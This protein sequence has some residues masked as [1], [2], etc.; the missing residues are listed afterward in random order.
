MSTIAFFFA[1]INSLSTHIQLYVLR[2][3]GLQPL[4]DIKINGRVLSMLLF[5][6]NGE[7]QDSLF[8]A[9]ERHR[10]C[11]LFYENGDVGWRWVG[12]LREPNSRPL[13]NQSI[14]LDTE[15]GLVGACCYQGSMTVI[16]LD[17][18]TAKDISTYTIK[19]AQKG[20]QQTQKSAL[21]LLNSSFDV[22]V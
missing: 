21:I 1:C 20:I 2:P 22:A 7:T 14:R 8:I 17:S 18:T 9:T 16:P 15:H 5:R 13:E 12:D 19:Y 10:F 3:D 4:Q 6:P 11:T